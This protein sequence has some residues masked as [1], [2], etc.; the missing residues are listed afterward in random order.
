MLYQRP[1]S[2]AACRLEPLE[3]RALLAG[4]AGFHY[5]SDLSPV[6]SVNGYGPVGLDRSNGEDAADDGR[7]IKLNGMRYTKGLGAHAAGELRYALNGQYKSFISDVGVDDE[8]GRNGSVTFRVYGD[9]QLLFDSGTM[10]G[11]SRTRRVNVDVTGRQTLRL[12][13]ADGLDGNT[14]D[15][16]DWAGARLT[17]PRGTAPA[18]TMPDSFTLEQPY[19]TV[20]AAGRF[21]DDGDGPWTA[22]VDFGDGA[23]EQRLRLDAG[24]QTFDLRHTYDTSRTADYTMT[25]R[26]S[27]GQATG[28]ARATVRVKNIPPTRVGLV[29]TDAEGNLYARTGMPWSTGGIFSDP[30]EFGGERYTYNVDFGD[31]SADLVGEPQGRLFDVNHT[32]EKA[33]TYT[34]TTTVTDEGGGSGSG[35]NTIIVTDPEYTYVGALRPFLVRGDGAN[36]Q[37]YSVDRSIGGRQL[38]I[39]GRRFDRGVGVMAN[40]DLRYDLSGGTYERLFASVGVDDGVGESGSVTFEVFADGARIFDSGVMTGKDR[41]R[42]LNLDVRGVTE[43]RLVVT[44]AGDG[45][46]SDY[47][48]WANIRLA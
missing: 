46:A 1:Q 38:K 32:F 45:N 9:D 48:D 23:G 17:M 2:A 30:G 41:H 47:A 3:A 21:V 39:N 16:G 15:H 7:Q 4:D 20:D 8:V 24:H 25:V 6:Y 12:V 18:V 11:V 13:L 35:T 34:V 40:S 26:I 14:A 44:D 10:T 27:D 36:G 22:T 31:G 29:G 43:L 37:A 42:A 19:G 28:I 5:L 33:G